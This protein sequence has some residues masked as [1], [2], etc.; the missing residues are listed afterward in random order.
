MNTPLP[1][2]SI[3]MLAYNVADYI[4][5]A[6]EGILRQEVDFPYQIVIAEDCSQ[7]DTRRIADMYAARYPDKILV[8]PSDINRGIPGNAAKALASC[9]GEYVAICDSD[10]IWVDYTKLKRQVDI[11]D[12]NPRY[13][14]VYSDVEIITEHGDVVVDDQYDYLRRRYVGGRVFTRL[15]NGN[16]INNSTG[17]FRRSLI[18]D[19]K[20]DPDRSYYSYDFLFWLH[21]ASQSEFCFMNEKTT[22]YRRHF[23]GVTTSDLKLPQN[24]KKFL[25]QLPSFLL[26][27]DKCRPWI[28]SNEEKVILFRK[29]LSVL[30]RNE[31]DVKTKLKI[32]RILPDYFPG[33]KSVVNIFVSRSRKRSAAA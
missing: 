26:T 14:A 16:F 25:H 31:A 10:D 27:F 29:M 13:G 5:A 23:G 18:G 33:I 7:D 12:S 21:I 28:P 15:L 9:T 32:S 30:Y 6:L 8:L 17:I 3:Y 2:V 20:I 22:Q 19:Y 24:R 1:K 4:E 11:L